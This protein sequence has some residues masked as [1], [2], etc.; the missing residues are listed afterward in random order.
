MPPFR[1]L[2]GPLEWLIGIGCS[3]CDYFTFDKSLAH[4]VT[5]DSFIDVQMNTLYESFAAVEDYDVFSA[6]FDK[7]IL[8]DSITT[9]ELIS[10]II[11]LGLDLSD[12]VDLASNINNTVFKELLETITTSDISSIDIEKVTNDSINTNESGFAELNPYSFGYFAEEYTE[13]ISPII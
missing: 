11:S 5:P 4:T 12:S 1:G 6:G 10:F 9:E 13:G 7:N 8:N 3:F 2:E